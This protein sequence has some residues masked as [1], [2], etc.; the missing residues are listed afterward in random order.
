MDV[1]QETMVK[2]VRDI[3]HILL[4]EAELERNNKFGLIFARHFSCR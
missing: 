1:E 3:M 2:L 4:P